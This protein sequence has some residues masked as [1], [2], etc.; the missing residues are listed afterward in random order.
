MSFWFLY[1]VVHY[2]IFPFRM[3]GFKNR[4]LKFDKIA[5][6]AIR[7]FQT[8]QS[9]KLK[10]IDFEYDKAEKPGLTYE[11]L[12]DYNKNRKYGAHKVLCFAPKKSMIF[13]FDGSVYVC[14]ENKQYSLGNITSKSVHDIWFGEK[15]AFIDKKINEDY[16]LDYGC[17]NCKY[18][19]QNK[20]HTLALAQV[21]D[22][23]TQNNSE[24]PAHLDFEI[25]NT[26]NLECIM[27][28]GIYSSSIQ[29]N[30]YK[31]PSNPILYD[32]SFVNQLDEF[33]PH[34][35]YINLIGGEPTLIQIY[36]KIIE[37]AININ[38]KIIF[39]IQTNAS[40]INE[41]FKKLLNTGNFQIGLSIDSL[42]KEL[43]EN[44]RIN[45]NFEKFM[46]NVNYYLQLHQENKI[47]VTV[48]IC[49][50]PF[51][52]RDMVDI[53]RMCNQNKVTVFL[54]VV[55]APY[56]NT[57]LSATP[58]YIDKVRSE[59]LSMSETLS[60][61][62]Y[63]ERGNYDRLM[64]FIQMLQKTKERVLFNENNRR[65]L[66]NKNFDELFEVFLKTLENQ[67][68]HPERNQFI[69]GISKY[70]YD[71]LNA[72]DEE[73]RKE[74]ILVIINSISEP[75][76]ISSYDEYV[77]W[78]IEFLDSLIFSFQNRDKMK[79]FIY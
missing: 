23:Q 79:E 62:N 42:N 60:R 28:S 41:R 30:R 11:E 58:E 72:L 51:N 37:R 53:I 76:V 19:I 69:N 45:L 3:S 43:T 12:I 64:D 6:V 61:T 34:V 63:F 68:V 8:Y 70:Y 24:Y 57:F 4:L 38:P 7:V 20:E 77:R 15:R 55:N 14:C 75:I 1:I 32:E 16:N 40:V 27:C 49:P 35:K 65:G 48:N 17:V 54:C 5:N 56:Y 71:S 67:I 21:F 2:E 10:F 73:S 26:C 78:S 18:K 50:M 52:W 39:H 31:K 66:I 47:K 13:S 9:V 33:L 59:L 22:L 44:I 29:A 25:H 46:D 74:I 36:Y